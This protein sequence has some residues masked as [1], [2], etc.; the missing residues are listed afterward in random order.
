MKKKIKKK[1]KMWIKAKLKNYQN[2][3]QNENQNENIKENKNEESKEEGFKKQTGTL[4][5]ANALI[6][7]KINEDFIKKESEENKYLKNFYKIKHMKM[8]IN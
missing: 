1:A 7:K 6:I 4:T 3:S 2:E 8:E 5:R